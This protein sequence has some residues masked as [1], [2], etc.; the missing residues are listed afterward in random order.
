MP[1]NCRVFQFTDIDIPDVNAAG[2]DHRF[3]ITAGIWLDGFQTVFSGFQFQADGIDAGHPVIGDVSVE[4]D[5]IKGDIYPGCLCAFQADTDKTGSIASCVGNEEAMLREQPSVI[6]GGGR[7]SGGEGTG[8]T[9]SIT[10]DTFSS[11]SSRGKP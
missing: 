7:L 6:K 5:L 1:G 2:K 4:E 8:Y 11:S 3:E 10:R 9:A